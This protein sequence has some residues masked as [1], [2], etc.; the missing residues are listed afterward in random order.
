[1]RRMRLADRLYFHFRYDDEHLIFA[2]STAVSNLLPIA[3]VT[4]LKPSRRAPLRPQVFLSPRRSSGRGCGGAV[5][6]SSVPTLGQNS[7]RPLSS[8]AAKNPR[9]S[10]RLWLPGSVADL[11]RWIH[12]WLNV[13]PTAWFRL[14][15]SLC[16]SLL[17]LRPFRLRRALS[18]HAIARLLELASSSGR[19]YRFGP[20]EGALA[21]YLRSVKHS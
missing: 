18:L 15:L 1:M 17:A 21:Q 20:P 10:C 2:F 7:L 19:R 4:P 3:F 9:A 12:P 6:S 11:P 13:F 16:I 5:I 8:F 14:G